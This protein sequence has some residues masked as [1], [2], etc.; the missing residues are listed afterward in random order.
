MKQISWAEAEKIVGYRVDRRLKYAVRDDGKPCD[1]SGCKIF[2]L[3]RWTDSCSGCY[4]SIDGYNPGYPTHPKHRCPVGHGCSEC[5]F[6]GVRRNGF[7]APWSK[8]LQDIERG[9]F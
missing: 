1:V 3:V 8:E 4:E 7:W 9:D 6:R 5:G 2:H